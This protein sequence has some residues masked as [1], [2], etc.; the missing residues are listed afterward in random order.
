MGLTQVVTTNTDRTIQLP[1]R[2]VDRLD[3]RAG[4]ELIIQVVEEAGLIL[5]FPSRRPHLP[6]S[7]TPTLRQRVRQALAKAGL[8]V[9]LDPAAVKRYTSRAGPRRLSPLK[10]GGQPVSEIIV[11]ERSRW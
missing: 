11:E 7:E 2:F 6:E 3:I 5:V 9:T 4:Q 8:L 1:K 10:I